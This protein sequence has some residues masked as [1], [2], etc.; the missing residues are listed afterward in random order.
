LSLEGTIFTIDGKKFVDKR[1]D[2]LAI[3]EILSKDID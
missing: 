2:I 3:E 1:T